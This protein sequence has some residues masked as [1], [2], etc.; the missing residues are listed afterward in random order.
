M[1]PRTGVPEGDNRG[2][3]SLGLCSQRETLQTQMYNEAADGLPPSVLES[4]SGAARVSS[5]EFPPASEEDPRRTT[6]GSDSHLAPDT[7][8]SRKGTLQAQRP[9]DWC[10]QKGTLQTHKMSNE[11]TDGLAPSVFAIVQAQLEKILAFFRQRAKKDPRR[12]TTGSDSRRAPEAWCSRMGT[13]QAQ[14]PT[15][16]LTLLSNT[17]QTKRCYSGSP[18]PISTV[19]PFVV[20]RRRRAIFLRGAVHDGRKDQAFP[21]PSSSGA[22]HVVS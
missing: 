5:Y 6:P 18:Y 10:S 21:R 7:W 1:L 4:F 13:L 11:A 15:R 9:E 14:I 19:V 2:P 3:K 20:C 12:D 17:P 16:L 8:C 22:H